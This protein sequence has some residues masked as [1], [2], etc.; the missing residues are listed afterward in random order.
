M[1]PGS[2]IPSYYIEMDVDNCY[3]FGPI[4]QVQGGTF[5]DVTFS[6]DS[7]YATINGRYLTAKKQTAG[8]KVFPSY[9][10]HIILGAKAKS[11][12]AVATI[13]VRIYDRPKSLQLIESF[14]VNGQSVPT[15]CKVMKTTG[16]EV[17]P[18]ESFDMFFK[19]IPSTAQQV[20]RLYNPNQ[21]MMNNIANMTIKDTP[22]NGSGCTTFTLSKN[23]YPFVGVSKIN[24]TE[25]SEYGTRIISKRAPSG[26]LRFVFCEVI[27][28]V[29]EYSAEEP[30]PLDF[31]TM[32][33]PC[34]FNY[35][36]GGRIGTIDGGLRIRKDPNG[37]RLIRE[38]YKKVLPKG[39]GM[40]Y[41]VVFEMSKDGRFP[42]RNGIEF[43]Y[44]WDE[45]YGSAKRYEPSSKSKYKTVHGY[46]IAIHPY[47]KAVKWSDYGSAYDY[48]SN[49]YF[50]QADADYGKRTC[51]DEDGL[52]LNAHYHYFNRAQ[53]SKF[54]IK[55]IELLDEYHKKYP[56][57]KYMAYYSDGSSF[58]APSWF[59]P[60]TT[61]ILKLE[62]NKD[63][64]MR[65]ALADRINYCNGNFTSPSSFWTCCLEKNNFAQAQFAIWDVNNIMMYRR[66]NKTEK[67]DFRPFHRF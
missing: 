52:R 58:A 6:I 42:N 7:K 44:H 36:I 55:P 64:T 10:D 15:A 53:D 3:D 56:T 67:Y 54:R 49:F 21:Y 39:S 50:K 28:H 61:E 40:P 33:I 9:P 11:G 35:S 24:T 32:S 1:A 48:S 30:K 12:S 29:V 65:K 45:L 38:T 41:A 26:A 59:I 25:S 4:V 37:R 13:L 63:T 60:S 17:K 31:M 23:A 57:I 22:G 47:G 34:G 66:N 16:Y 2:V 5:S 14:P 18:G 27:I 19:V 62:F 46:A 8:A 43:T 51:T 20:V